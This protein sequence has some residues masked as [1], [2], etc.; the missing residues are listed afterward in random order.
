M[1]LTT[2]VFYEGRRHC[3]GSTISLNISD[4][5][6]LVRLASFAVKIYS[7]VLTTV[8][9]NALGPRNVSALKQPRKTNLCFDHVYVLSLFLLLKYI[10]K[11]L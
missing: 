7:A 10:P 1:H 2:G 6:N 11:S 5:I 8:T 9:S 3:R 4:Y